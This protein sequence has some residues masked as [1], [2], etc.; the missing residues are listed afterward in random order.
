[1]MKVNGDYSRD[2]LEAIAKRLG[3]TDVDYIEKTLKGE[4]FNPDD[5][6]FILRELE[7]VKPIEAH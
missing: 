2:D 5:A 1:M 6:Q 3:W 4:V 7:K